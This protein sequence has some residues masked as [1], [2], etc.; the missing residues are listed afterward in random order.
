[1]MNLQGDGQMYK[2]MV[3]GGNRG[4]GYELVKILHKEGN[5]VYPVVRTALASENLKSVF[6]ERIYPII[7]DISLDQSETTIRNELNQL[8]DRLD[9]LINNAGN[10][11]KGY[12]IK[13]VS[14]EEVQEV[15]NVH[16]LGVIRTV[17]ATEKFLEKSHFPRI[18]NISSRLGSIHMMANQEFT[19][20]QTSYSYRVAKAAQNML[21]VC[22]NEELN[23]K[24]IF[25]HAIH[26]GKLK[27]NQASPDADMEVSIGANNI[28]QWILQMNKETSGE[29][30]QPGVGH[31]VW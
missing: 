21:T 10:S 5:E 24:G 12:E 20:L 2:V 6:K 28:Y 3:T 9:I 8:T 14:T 7:A 17:K 13:E 16:C 31:L 30:I 29:F 18:I 19:H 11:G 1:M 27:T 4:L 26:P 25:V 22:L 15:F 23:K